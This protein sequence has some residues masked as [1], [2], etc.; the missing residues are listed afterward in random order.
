MGRWVGCEVAFVVRAMSDPTALTI[1]KRG[2]PMLSATSSVRSTSSVSPDCEEP[3]WGV[4]GDHKKSMLPWGVRRG[5]G[6]GCGACEMTRSPPLVLG[7]K[8]EVSS[9]ASMHCTFRGHRG[10]APGNL[11]PRGCASGYRLKGVE[12]AHELRPVTGGVVGGAARPDDQVLDVKKIGV[13]LSIDGDAHASKGGPERKKRP[14]RGGW[15]R[16]STSRP[17][18]LMNPSGSMR[19]P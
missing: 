18:S 4:R 6:R 5:T 9:A 12:V 16:A 3:P 7:M 2:I 17:P 1:E 10:Q 14:G 19:P 8:S 11:S 15:R 13:G